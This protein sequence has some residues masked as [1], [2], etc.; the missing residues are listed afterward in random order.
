[1]RRD[2][3]SD[4]HVYRGV[5]GATAAHRLSA[6]RKS[7]RKVIKRHGSEAAVGLAGGV[8]SALATLASTDAPDTKGKKSNL[9]KLSQQVSKALASDDR[10][11]SRKRTAKKT[12]NKRAKREEESPEADQSE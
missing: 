11:K 2:L 9:G 5:R 8:A 7:V 4:A 10:K 6:I 3:G 12:H 1:V